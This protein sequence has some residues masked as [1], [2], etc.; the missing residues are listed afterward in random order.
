MLASNPVE[1]RKAIKEIYSNLLLPLRR[2]HYVSTMNWGQ[3]RRDAMLASNPIEIRKA[4]IYS[5]LLLSL[6]RNH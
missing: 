6:R 3:I 5:D 1:I 4:I 2:N